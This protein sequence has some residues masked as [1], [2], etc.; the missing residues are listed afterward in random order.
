M[1]RRAGAEG[2]LMREQMAYSEKLRSLHV[3]A[4]EGLRLL[5]LAPRAK[6]IPGDEAPAPQ[7]AQSRYGPSPASTRRQCRY[8]GRKQ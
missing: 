2:L 8:G 1:A 3:P 4:S 6:P 5:D 7:S